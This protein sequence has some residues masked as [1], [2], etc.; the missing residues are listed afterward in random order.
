[1]IIHGD[2]LEVL[3]TLD[4]EFIDVVPTSPP[5]NIGKDYGNYKDDLPYEDYLNWMEEIAV[6][7]K[8]VLK[9][10][11]SIFL[12]IGNTCKQPFIN[13][14]VCQRFRKHLILQNDIV[15]VKSVSVTDKDQV[16]SFGHFKP[17]VSKRF[18]NQQHESVYHFTKT[19]ENLIDRLAVG[20]PYEDKSNID[21][22][23][24]AEKKDKR[25]RGNVWHIPYETVKSK[26]VHP[27]G[28]PVKLPEF[29]IQLHGITEGMK[30]LDPFLG[31]GTTLL[32]C[33]NLG[34]SGIGIELNEEFCNISKDNLV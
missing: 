30:V 2:A 1:M 23:K 5:Y 8:R 18:L 6:A 4:P 25:C 17:I 16:R 28:F 12:N 14:D 19:G 32:A 31:A 9:P 15:W 26:K 22:W 29:C 21:R 11:G 34:V 7:L 13:M 10:T 33:K 24:G 27:A 3:N 20:V